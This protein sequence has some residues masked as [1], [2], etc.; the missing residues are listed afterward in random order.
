MARNGGYGLGGVGVAGEA[1][2]LPR[3][4]PLLLPSP[5]N[6]FFGTLTQARVTQEEL[7]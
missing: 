6:T 2:L 1:Q 5:L 7:S 3:L 4:L